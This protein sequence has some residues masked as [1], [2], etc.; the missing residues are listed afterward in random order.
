MN[1]TKENIE[2][3][4]YEGENEQVEFKSVIRDPLLLSKVIGAFSNQNGGLIIVGV[5][6]PIEIIGCDF[7]RLERILERTKAILTPTPELELS[8]I[9]IDGKTLGLIKVEKGEGLTFSAGGVYERQCEFIRSMS[10]EELKN[11]IVHFSKPSTQDSLAK[12]IAQQTKIIEELRDDIKESNSFKSKIKNYLIGG[13]V[14]AI[15]SL[16]LTLL[17]AG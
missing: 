11:K 1:Y 15:L 17:F 13:I 4:L 8:K 12:A 7:H 14:G 5:K 3:I 9:E 6:E 16:I 2:K 10:P